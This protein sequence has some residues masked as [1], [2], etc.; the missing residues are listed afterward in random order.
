MTSATDIRVY[1]HVVD[2][3]HLP[4]HV[5]Y[6]PDSESQFYSSQ[7]TF[8]MHYVIIVCSDVLMYASPLC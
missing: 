2:S 5:M 4:V 1:L 3:C 8:M 7:S 6:I